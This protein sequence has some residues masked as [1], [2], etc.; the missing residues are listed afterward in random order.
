M[1]Q[2]LLVST[3]E[4]GHA[5]RIHFTEKKGKSEAE[6]TDKGRERP[7]RTTNILRVARVRK[8][9]DRNVVKT[10]RKGEAS[11]IG[12]I[13]SDRSLII[14]GNILIIISSMLLII[15]SNH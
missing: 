10:T 8:R 14:L 1:R 15:L 4:F 7:E 6:R 12:W 3:N 13:C 5:G 11:E 2:R 9:L